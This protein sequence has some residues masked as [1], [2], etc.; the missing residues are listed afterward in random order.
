M[1]MISLRETKN[2]FYTKNTTVRNQSDWRLRDDD[3]DD[4]DI[5][6]TVT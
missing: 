5:S 6:I 3:D 2:R 4:N 1:M